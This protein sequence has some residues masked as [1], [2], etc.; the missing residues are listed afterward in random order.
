M[1]LYG[2]ASTNFGDSLAL[3]TLEVETDALADSSRAQAASEHVP[4]SGHEAAADNRHCASDTCHGSRD[5]PT[6]AHT[7]TLSLQL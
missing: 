2:A 7:P 1:D 3:G 5:N 6:R 4:S